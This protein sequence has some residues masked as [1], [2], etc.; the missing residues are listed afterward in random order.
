MSLLTNLKVLENLR[1]DGVIDVQGDTN[2]GN[3][4]NFT[5]KDSNIYLNKN[6]TAG[7]KNGGF[8]VNTEAVSSVD[9][10][11]IGPGPF[12]VITTI[13]P[14]GFSTGDI[15]QLS[16]LNLPED[17]GVYVVNT[18]TSAT[19]FNVGNF[20]KPPFNADDFVRTN[21]PAEQTVAK[22]KATKIVLSLW[23]QGGSEGAITTSFGSSRDEID[24]NKK[25]LKKRRPLLLN[26]TASLTLPDVVATAAR[27]YFIK[28]AGAT[29]V[30]LPDITT[31]AAST[32]F[33]E[34]ITFVRDSADVGGAATVA[35]DPVSVE[36]EG[37]TT[38]L[39][40]D[41]FPYEKVT[42]LAVGPTA[43]AA[44]WAIE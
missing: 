12:S 37:D 9:I 8:V 40:L 10:S 22:G 16:G 20:L 41:Y 34:R 7:T 32:W 14:N 44:Y 4:D 18:I 33:G 25:D 21:L 26:E 24:N 27:T 17:E 11:S 43:T 5:V 36:V 15:V 23:S 38:D 28:N 39:S 31:A 6:M 35:I 29:T 42:L 3:T 30:T 19:E 13:D 2:S 1:I